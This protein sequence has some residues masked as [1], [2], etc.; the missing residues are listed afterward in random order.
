MNIALFLPN[1]IGDA[2]MATP[3]LRAIRRHFNGAHIV[4]V[5][6]PYVADVVEGSD[7][8]DE[9]IFAD[10]K[11][12]GQSIPAVAWQ[13][14]RRKIDLAILFTNSFRTAFISRLGG[15]KK[16]IGHA[17]HGRSLLLTDAVSPLRDARGKLLP[18]PVIDAYNHLAVRAGCPTPGNRMEL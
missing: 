9:M 5:L 3:A 15:C 6:R 2:V 8:L 4:G 7:W 11:S 14:R 16:R 17:L 10:G 13:L 12:W 18:S 1:W